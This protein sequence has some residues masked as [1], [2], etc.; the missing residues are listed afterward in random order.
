MDCFLFSK[1]WSTF[2]S[3]RCTQHSK[4]K[5]PL[6]SLLRGAVMGR[7]TSPPKGSITVLIP[8]T[9]E[10]DLIWKWN[11]LEVIKLKLGQYSRSYSNM[12]GILIK[13]EI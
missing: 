11:L 1:N 6:E 12:T 3:R 2:E 13:G 5:K 10:C 4:S 9:S 8:S 7:I